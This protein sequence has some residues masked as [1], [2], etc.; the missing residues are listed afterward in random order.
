MPLYDFY[1]RACS[2]HFELRV[3]IN[4]YDK[5]AKPKCPACGSSETHR[6]FAPA[7]ILS[8]SPN[9]GSSGGG[10]CPGGRCG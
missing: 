4:E 9:R 2:K 10:C 1:C 5:A 6:V 8:A 3:A 7:N